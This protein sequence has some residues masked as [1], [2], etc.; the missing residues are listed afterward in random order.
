MTTKPEIYAY[1]EAEKATLEYF[2]GDELATSCVIN[3]YLLHDNDGNLLEKTPTDMHWRI[4]NEFARVEKQKFKEPLKA[5][6]IFKLMDKFRYISCQGSP[7]FGI[8]ND[9]QIVSLSNCYLLT[10]PDDSYNSIL[11][12]DKQ[13]V[14]ISKRR[15]GVGIDLSKLRP[16]GSVTKNA[17][18][19]STGIV[20]WME[21]Y[22]NSIREVGQ[23][24]RR[25]A[26]MLTLD[27]HHP[28]ILD[29]C[30]IKNDPTKVT[31]ANISVRLSKEFIAAVENDT[32]YELRFPVD[33][34]EKKIKPLISKMVKAKDV[35]DIIIHS[36]WLRAEPGILNWSCVT[37]QSPADCYE[38]YSSKGTNPC[39]FSTKQDIWVITNNGIKEIKTVSHYDKIFIN[40]TLE[41]V[42]TS[43]YFSSGKAKIY[44]VEFKNGEQLDITENH[45][46]CVIKNKR[47]G[48]I[49]DY[50]EG[51]LVELKDLRVGDKIA[52]HTNE[53]QNIIWGKYGDYDLGLVM[54][55]LTGDGCLSFLDEAETHPATILEFWEQ[56]FDVGDKLLEIFTKWGYGLTLNDNKINN[57]KRISSTKF[58]KEFINKFEFNIWLFKSETKNNPFIFNC[59]KEFLKGY[60][61]SYFSADGT[62]EFC[63]INK[64]YNIQLSSINKNRL[65]QIKYLLN[66]FGIKSSVTLG[67]KAGASEF[68]NGGCYQTKDCWRLTITGLDN[69][70]KYNR[71]FGFVADIKQKKLD[72]LCKINENKNAKC[73]NYT[74]IKSISYIGEEETGC[75]SVDKYHKFTANGIISGNS[76]LNLSELDSC[77]LLTLVLLSY[78]QYPYTQN[79]YFDY[80]LF[81]EHSKIAQ[82]LM[83]DL[84]D[85][86]SEKIQKIIEKIQ[87]DPE[88]AESKNDELKMWNTIKAN[89][90]DGRRTGT[91]ITALGDTLAALGI[92]YGSKESIR[93]TDRIYKTLKFACYESSIEMAKELGHFK[94]FDWEKEKDCPFFKRFQ[95]EVVTLNGLYNKAHANIKDSNGGDLSSVIGFNLLEDMKKYG[96]RN[97]ALITTAPTGTV[98]ILTQT[99]SGI[100]PLFMMS[101]KRR[102]KIT[103]NDPNAKV[104]FIDISG[105]KWQEFEVYHRR[106]KDWMAENFE[107]DIKKSPWYGCCAEDLDW[108][109][110][111]KLQ[112]AAQSHVCHSISST[113][114]LPQE[115]KE[116]KV[117]KIYLEAFRN[118]IKGLTIYRK[119]CRDGVLVENKKQINNAA[120]RPDK[121]PCEIFRVK[122]KG[123]KF[124]V[125]VGLMDG[126][127]YEIFVGEDKLLDGTEGISGFLEKLSR[128]KYRLKLTDESVVTENICD[129]LTD[130]EEVLT[131]LV[132]T[133]L[134]H[135]TP[136][137]FI[138]HQ[139]EKT[140]GDLH[141]AAKVICRVLKKYIKDGVKVTGECCPDC[142]NTNLIRNN[143]CASCS[144]GWSKCS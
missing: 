16:K 139:M 54:G 118:N 84:V 135:N 69:I 98:S 101:Y 56:E 64:N 94:E 34:K 26:L 144:C 47:C 50:S 68:I 130:S 14:N 59:T 82:R 104:D 121:L 103:H 72:N 127:P 49:V 20:S 122:I 40:E 81:Y 142:Q 134:R 29:F 88:S 99:T 140:K 23:N 63:Q 67:K 93:V 66:L 27:I 77:R 12:T 114:N 65:L 76:E 35:W 83:D 131:R 80:K 31:G 62:V 43:G 1:K 123:E 108:I 126:D 137:E 10:S 51:D 100:E 7:M 28:D 53:A 48:S 38:R 70:R 111:V 71:E 24:S 133:A 124:F 2:G 60:L 33:Y 11:D 115:I 75:I 5:D 110:R 6:F 86:E 143:G 37:E 42:N 79:A 95:E 52:V 45:K 15:G 9:Y 55:W 57:K 90:D 85:L 120:K 58:T 97:V 17:A 13:L 117:G 112:A 89:N 74:T 92:K 138:V 119:G 39:C 107:S 19:T 8:G 78:V 116:E 132:S 4:A 96:R 102:K 18:K 113:L 136:L 61:S 30:T 46:L 73:R 141:S 36:A 3:K 105:D 125:V 109:Q 21:R 128:G 44:K 41:W 91:G 87:S 106:I 25:G 129:Y 22:S 32:E